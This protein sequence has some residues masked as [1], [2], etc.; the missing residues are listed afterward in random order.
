MDHGLVTE[1]LFRL[2]EALVVYV[3]KETDWEGY[4]GLWSSL[5]L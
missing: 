1:R 3:R 2:W 4:S 5:G